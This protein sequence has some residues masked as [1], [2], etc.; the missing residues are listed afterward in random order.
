MGQR[1]PDRRHARRLVVSAATFWALWGVAAASD[2]SKT[3]ALIPDIRTFDG[4]A[5]RFAMVMRRWTAAELAE[6]A[7]IN[8]K[9]VYCALRG[10]RVNDRTAL[11][12]FKALAIREPMTTG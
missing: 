12:I 5:L 2:E 9:S 3:L 4:G 7:E 11:A 8:A 1:L 10:Q 6:V